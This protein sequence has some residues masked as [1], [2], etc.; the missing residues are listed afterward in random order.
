MDPRT[1]DALYRP[2]RI[3]PP[4]RRP[5]VVL[6]SAVLWLLTAMSVSWL[7]FLVGMTA[8]W[9]AAAGAPVGGFLLCC[10]AVLCAVARACSSRPAGHRRYGVCPVTDAASCWELWPARSR[11]SWRRPRGSPSG[12][13][14]RRAPCPAPAHAAGPPGKA[15]DPT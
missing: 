15:K 3:A 12:D 14:F 8:L 13:R 9:G 4:P 1:Y 6:L 7:C 11:W 2:A 10:S 5:G